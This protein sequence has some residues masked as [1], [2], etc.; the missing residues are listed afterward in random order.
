[1]N[2]ATVLESYGSAITQALRRLDRVTTV[3]RTAVSLAEATDEEWQLANQAI[4]IG[5]GWDVAYR[6]V[7]TVDLPGK[8]FP[9]TEHPEGPSARWNV[10]RATGRRR[11][12][13][14]PGS[15]RG[16][17]GWAA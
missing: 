8:E 3:A 6:L 16:W 10:R 5:R 12:W 14:L 13:S 11:R 7:S 9:A 2:R 15:G 1:V 4:G 17:P